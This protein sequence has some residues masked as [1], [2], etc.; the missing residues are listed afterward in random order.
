MSF[1]VYRGLEYN[2]LSGEKSE[3]S[4][5]A[6]SLFFFFFKRGERFFIEMGSCVSIKMIYYEKSVNVLRSVGAI[7]FRGPP[8]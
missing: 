2:S 3:R 7:E 8:F 5:F 1:P 6:E 4:I